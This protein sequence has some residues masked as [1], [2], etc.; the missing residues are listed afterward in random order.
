MLRRRDDFRLAARYVAWAFSEV[1]GVEKVV[2]FGSAAVPLRKEVPRFRDFRRAGIEV[3]HECKDV[4]LAVWMTETGGLRSLQE[5]RAAG[6]N[7]LLRDR[8]VGV[9]HHQVDVFLFDSHTGRYVGRLCTFNACPKGKPECLVPGCGEIPF[10]RRHEGFTF[11]PDV[12]DPDRCRVLFDREK[13]TGFF[14]RFGGPTA[15]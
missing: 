13:G 11:P 3:W 14:S 6:L 7:S 12:L 4:D 5:A 10:L 15:L 2:L 1:P 9:A 8:S